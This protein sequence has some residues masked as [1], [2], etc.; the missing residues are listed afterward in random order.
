MWM[1]NSMQE[2]AS[3]QLWCR[4]QSCPFLSASSVRFIVNSLLS[5]FPKVFLSSRQKCQLFLGF[6]LTTSVVLSPELS[7][8]AVVECTCSQFSQ[9]IWP[10]NLNWNTYFGT[11]QALVLKDNW[12]EWWYGWKSVIQRSGSRGVTSTLIMPF[13]VSLHFHLILL[14]ELRLGTLH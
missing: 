2:F 9:S 12:T 7:F 13:S 14:L 1:L 5:L 11:I 10:K 6:H 3:N 4:R 8:K